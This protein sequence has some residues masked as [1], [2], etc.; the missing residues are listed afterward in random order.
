MRSLDWSLY[1]AYNSISR[2]NIKV[3]LIIDPMILMD[4]MIQTLNELFII[5]FKIGN[6]VDHSPFA[7]KRKYLIY[8]LAKANRQS[9]N[10][11][12]I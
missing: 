8:L 4:F 11:L 2:L 10:S 9:I 3:I 1:K 7:E 5:S 12:D 6:S